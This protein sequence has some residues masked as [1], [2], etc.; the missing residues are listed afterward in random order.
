MDYSQALVW[1]SAR[2]RLAKEAHLGRIR[3]LLQKLGDPQNA[4]H[5]VHVAGTN[6]KGSVVAMLSSV[7]SAAGYRVGMNISPYVLQF[8]ERI[9]VNGE[10]IPEGA[11]AEILMKVRRA[12]ESMEEPIIEFE[13]VT[14]AALL[15]FA[16]EGCDII[17]LEAGIGGGSDATNIIPPP[18]V[19]CL[20]RIGMDH[21]ELLGDTLA[22]I[23]AEKCGI[24]KPGCRVVSYPGQ[25]AE[26][27]AV[28]EEKAAAIGCSLTLPDVSA[29]QSYEGKPFEN[30]ISYQ[31]IGLQ[32][33]FPGAHQALNAAVA[34]EAVFQLR[35]C[36][37][38]ISDAQIIKGIE[39]ARF[40][41]RIE[42]ISR[43]PL[44]ILDGAHNE[45][46]AAALAEA[47][48]QAGV[49]GLSAVV[50]ILR[51]K[52][53]AGFLRL[54]SPYIHI[55]YTVA[56]PSPRALPAEELAAAARPYVEHCVACA[57][58]KE[59]V[60][61]A[62]ADGRGVLVC[63]SLYLASEARPLLLSPEN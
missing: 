33:P 1:L 21:T 11:L 53:A 35:G 15:Y 63:G 6:G 51:D 29:L 57:D 60:R 19:T 38:T 54:L 2:P 58:V 16:R 32:L 7:L 24:I 3:C 46:S 14:A 31:G 61:L 27:L 56:P 22:A 12:A 18:L 41:A 20:M 25:P 43:E 40:P 59:A 47:L 50:G 48:A 9:Q 28:I 30:H 55:I 8:R 52:D 26:A 34:V 45:D 10:M 13:A 37:Y 4:L 62:R 23:A 5:F 39:T 42:L 17:C 36:G 49:S 44:V